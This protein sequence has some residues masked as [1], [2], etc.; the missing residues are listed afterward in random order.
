MAMQ[1]SGGGTLASV[2]VS[3]LSSTLF[4]NSQPI[5][6]DTVSGTPYDANYSTGQIRGT[7]SVTFAASVDVMTAIKAAGLIAATRSVTQVSISNGQ[8]SHTLTSPYINSFSVSCNAQDNSIVAPS[9]EFI[10]LN[11]VIGANSTGTPPSQNSFIPQ[12]LSTFTGSIVDG[13]AVSFDLT[14]NNNLFVLYTLDGTNTGTPSSIQYGLLKVSGSVTMYGGTPPTAQGVYTGNITGIGTTLNMSNLI[15][16][17]VHG[18]V[19]GP[20]NKPFQMV[21]FQAIGNGGAAPIS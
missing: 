19:T 10:A 1:F 13:Q 7:G 2:P 15:N 12:F 4:L 16:M 9:V 14:V 6:P 5:I 21:T 17:D 8:V 11:D 3:V 18:D 20:N